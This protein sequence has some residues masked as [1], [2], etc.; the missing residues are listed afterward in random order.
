MTAAR[1]AAAPPRSPS[2]NA[3]PAFCFVALVFVAFSPNTGENDDRAAV[4]RGRPHAR[5]ASPPAAKPTVRSLIKVSQD[6]QK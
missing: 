6:D 5:A 3:A 4:N 1:L 2:R